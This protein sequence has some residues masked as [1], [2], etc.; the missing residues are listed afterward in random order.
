M[1]KVLP[2]VYGRNKSCCKFIMV[3]YGKLKIEIGYFNIFF[4]NLFHLSEK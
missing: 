1:V 4:K 3:A 2:K